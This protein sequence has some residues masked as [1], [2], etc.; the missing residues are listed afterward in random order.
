MT[1]EE[2]IEFLKEELKVQVYA[3]EYD[4]QQTIKVRLYITGEMIDSD[5]AGFRLA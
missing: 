1:K 3:E 4:G 2:I 5:Y